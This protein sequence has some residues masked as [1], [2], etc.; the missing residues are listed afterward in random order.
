M[1][2]QKNN[3]NYG[4]CEICGTPLQENFINQDFW[5]NGQLI[6]VENVPAGV[7]PSCG[8]KV[9]TAEVGEW[10]AELIKSSERIAKA[11]RISVPA[12]KFEAEGVAA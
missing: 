11:P 10:I 9:V 7:C 5:I 1:K 6:V 2:T 3:Y 8:E 4:E 12:I